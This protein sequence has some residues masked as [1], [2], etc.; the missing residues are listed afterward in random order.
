MSETSTSNDF[1]TMVKKNPS[2][3]VYFFLGICCLLALFYW[4]V[5]EALFHFYGID[6]FPMLRGRKENLTQHGL[7]DEEWRTR[8]L[9]W[10]RDELAEK[11]RIES[12]IRERREKYLKFLKPYTKVKLRFLTYSNFDII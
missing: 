9:E 10:I 2:I 5:S 1:I 8:E 11:E 7:S 4:G 3:C 6:I 12:L